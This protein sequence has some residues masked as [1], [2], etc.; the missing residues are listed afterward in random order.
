MCFLPVDTG[1]PTLCFLFLRP[2]TRILRPR[3]LTRDEIPG[4]SARLHGARNLPRQ[5]TGE[6]LG[7]KARMDP[8][9]FL[10]TSFPTSPAQ[11]PLRRFLLWKNPTLQP[12]GREAPQSGS[13]AHVR[14]CSGSKAGPLRSRLPSPEPER[15]T[16][17]LNRG[18]WVPRL[19]PAWRRTAVKAGPGRA[20]AVLDFPPTPPTPGPGGDQ[21]VHEGPNLFDKH[22]HD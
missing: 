21:R 9:L 22:S 18:V 15:I 8:L 14:S 20:V 5:S 19:S 7:A 4:P 16:W 6:A 12:V 13:R 1:V 3:L 11:S 10:L 17:A 2:P